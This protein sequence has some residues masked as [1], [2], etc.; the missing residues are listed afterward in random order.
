MERRILLQPPAL[1]P[2]EP[3][4]VKLAWNVTVSGILSVPQGATCLVLFAHG[5]GI[6]GPDNVHLAGVLNKYGVATLLFNL[7]TNEEAEFDEK[8]GDLHNDSVMLGDR[9]ISA[10]IWLE[11]Q[12][13]LRSLALGIFGDDVGAAAALVAAARLPTMIKA[14]VARSGDLQRS[15]AAWPFIKAPTLLL[16][17][18]ND[19]HREVNDKALSVMLCEKSLRTFERLSN[20]LAESEDLEFVGE[21]AAA[22]F[23]KHL[24]A[25]PL[26]KNAEGS[27][28]PKDDA[29][30]QS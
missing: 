9:L 10:T 19:P 2:G 5:T 1:G 15:E 28:H 11:E 14:V 23:I 8:T 7:L 17:A 22:W 3:V 26:S 12:R 20:I 21:M 13:H 4:L 6:C 29:H 16:L 18:Q 25:D 24:S 30:S 27:F